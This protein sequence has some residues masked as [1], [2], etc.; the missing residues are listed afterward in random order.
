MASISITNKILDEAIVALKTH[1][2]A[3]LD[4]DSL[5]KP[6]ATKGYQKMLPKR[7][8]LIVPN[9]VPVIRVGADEGDEAV[10]SKVGGTDRGVT[11]ATFDILIYALLK[12]ADRDLLAEQVYAYGDWVEQAME[13]AITGKL[14]STITSYLGCR[15]QFDIPITEQEGVWF[16][17]VLIRWRVTKNRT[18]GKSTI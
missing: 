13:K 15:K 14:N 6:D 18:L 8:R 17:A 1:L 4:S 5:P 11:A 2:P 10:K 7:F 16:G 12:N 9:V 3:L